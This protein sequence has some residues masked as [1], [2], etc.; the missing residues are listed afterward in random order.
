M[1]TYSIRHR[2]CTWRAITRYTH[3]GTN[4]A[5]V[6]SPPF[7][8][9]FGELLL[10]LSSERR[11]KHTEKHSCDSVIDVKMGLKIKI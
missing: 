7:Y 6:K 4:A 11:R 10:H 8:R 2:V 9:T 1:F 3:T 5:I